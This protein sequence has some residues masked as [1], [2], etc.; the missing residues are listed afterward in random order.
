MILLVLFVGV[1]FRRAVDFFLVFLLKVRLSLALI[2]VNSSNSI[3]PNPPPP[4]KIIFA[5]R[6]VFRNVTARGWQGM[7]VL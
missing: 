7:A 6:C 1:C 5:K 4:S 3:L 2:N